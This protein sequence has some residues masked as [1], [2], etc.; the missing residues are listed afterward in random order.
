MIGINE[1]HRLLNSTDMIV[2]VALH[3][4][5]KPIIRE[6]LGRLKAAERERDALRAKIAEMEKREPVGVMY[7]GSYYGYELP[8]WEFDADQCACD[9]L[10]EA[11][12]NNPTTLKLYA[13]PDTKGE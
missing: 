10:N 1:L 8:E 9:K 13:I 7:V 3:A 2:G 5:I 4:N 11:Y 12:V 6:I